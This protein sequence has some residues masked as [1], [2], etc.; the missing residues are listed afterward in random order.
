MPRARRARVPVVVTVV[1]VLAAIA[2]GAGY[3]YLRLKDNADVAALRRTTDG[4]AAAWG[5]GRLATVAYT[6]ARPDA[7]AADAQAVFADLTPAATDRPA[8]VTVS[9][10]DRDPQHH[11][12]ARAVLHVTW[13]LDGAHSWVYDTTVGLSRHDGAWR[14]DFAPAMLLTGLQP[15]EVLV[16]AR[17]TPPRAPILGARDDVLVTERPVVFVGVQPG[18]TTDVTA[19]SVALGGLLGVDAAALAKRVRAAKPSAFVDVITLRRAD[20]DALRARL[21]PIKGAVFREGSLALAP[22]A[23]FARALLGSVGAPTAEI[24]KTSAGRVHAGDLTGLSGLQR[25]Y[26]QRLAGAAG[27]QVRRVPAPRASPAGTPSNRPAETVFEVAPLPG[28]PVRLTL[29]ARVQAAAESALAAAPKP[30][31]LVAVRVGTGEVLA[32]ANG[33]PGAAGYD[34]ALLGRYPPGST[35]KIASGYALLADGLTPGSPVPCPPSVTVNGKVFTNA[36]HEVLG[37]V[38][39]HVDFAKSCNAAFVGSAGRITAAQLSSA[40]AALGYGAAGGVGVEAF[41]GSVPQRATPVEHAA[42]MIGQGTVL[43]SPLTV[44]TV[45]ASVASGR[46]APPVLVRDPPATVPAATAPLSARAVG[47]VRLMMREVVTSGTG[48]ALAGVPGGQVRGKTGTAEFGSANPP[49]SH[50]WFTGYQGDVAFA[51][52][53]EDGGFGAKA[54][55]PLAAAFLR[56]LAEG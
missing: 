16:T 28:Q 14:V 41:G 42:D 36:E 3:V 53:V 24:V 35:F 44:A 51:V 37:L 55:A 56:S 29:D 20:Y 2:A 5:G 43:A 40:A 52:I 26:D 30:A 38:P 34:R 11:D 22:T 39:F 9:A 46:L 15:G 8:T 4:F 18:R 49:H 48:T 21:Q 13:H 17:T 19:T 31:G 27:L 54:A 50:A 10:V 1:V 12:R 23:D 6:G 7:V 45:S 32:V 33:G 47:G 25:T